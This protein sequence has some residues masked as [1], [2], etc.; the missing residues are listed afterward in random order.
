MIL[1]AIIAAPFA[2]AA[3]ILAWCL[4][5]AGRLNDEAAEECVRRYREH[6]GDDVCR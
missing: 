4:C 2:I 6:E 5:R 3:A 1:A